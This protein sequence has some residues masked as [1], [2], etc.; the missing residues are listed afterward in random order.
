MLFN[1]VLL[2]KKNDAKKREFF[3]NKLLSAS[4]SLARISGTF[5]DFVGVVVFVCL[6]FLFS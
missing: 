2:K 1:V 4:F 6:S 5:F 3:D